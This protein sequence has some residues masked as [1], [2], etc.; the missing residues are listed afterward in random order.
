[1]IVL[2]LIFNL[3]TRVTVLTSSSDSLNLC[4]MHPW[5]YAISIIF[6]F[7]FSRCFSYYFMDSRVWS[8]T[9]D[10]STSFNFFDIFVSFLLLERFWVHKM[11]KITLSKEMLSLR[12]SS[13]HALSKKSLC[14]KELCRK[15]S[16]YNSQ[17]YLCFFV[18]IQVI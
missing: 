17:S 3:L 16:F 6:C 18:Y 1:M 10:S 12:H 7:S 11:L 14:F 13:L 8:S 4:N 2:L 15:L 9:V 5:L